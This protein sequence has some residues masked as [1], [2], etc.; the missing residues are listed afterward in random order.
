MA[1]KFKWVAN[2]SK[3]TKKQLPINELDRKPGDITA[4]SAEDMVNDFIASPEM[5]QLK[6]I[7]ADKSYSNNA[8]QLLSETP[9]LTKLKIRLLWSA[10][11]FQRPVD[12]SHVLKIVTEWDSRRPAPVNVVYNPDTK[13]HYI[14]DGQHTVLAYA[15]RGFLG[16][17][18][19]VDSADWLDIEVNSQ[20]VETNDMA[21][22]SEHFQGINGGDK[23][24]LTPFDYWKPKVLGKRQHSPNKQTKDTYEI[25]FAKQTILE[26]YK[27]IPVHQDSPDRFKPGALVHVNNLDKMSVEDVAFMAKNHNTY[28]SQEPI[29]PTEM[30]PLQE[31]RNRCVKAGAETDSKEFKEFMQDLNSIIKHVLGGFAE[32]RH[33]TQEVYP[34]YH[35]AAFGET[36]SAP[37][38]ASLSLLLKMYKKAGGT[39]RYAPSILMNKYSENNTDLFDHLDPAIRKM[40]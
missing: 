17:F 9:L 13:Q 8:P 32:L 16:L 20:V 25:A 14:T 11:E 10:L 30:L 29:D 15:V 38:D 23:L 4:R 7:L 40:F 33:K 2:T 19:D 39:Y 22:C 31:L 6:A 3:I 21:F 34:K 24:P 35:L 1:V 26:K 36:K 12:F 37:K 28:W 18:K 5:A 27:I